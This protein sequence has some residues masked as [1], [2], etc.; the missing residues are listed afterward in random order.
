MKQWWRPKQEK[1]RQAI[2]Y[3]R[4]SAQERRDNSIEI[5]RDKVLDFA[6]RHSIKIIDGLEIDK[7]G[8]TSFIIQKDSTI[9]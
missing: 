1:C 2:V 7:N 6:E 9:Q 3:Y 5:Q 8:I 4:H